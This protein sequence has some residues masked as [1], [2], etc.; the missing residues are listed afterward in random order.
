MCG[1]FTLAVADPE[2][3]AWYRLAGP[4]GLPPRY[5][6]APTQPVVAVCLD[7]AGGRVLRTFRW[8][9]VPS[10]SREGLAGAPLINARAETAP[11]RPA[12]RQAFARG[13]CLVPA[14]GFFEWDRSRRPPRASLFHPAGGG[15][16]SFA[17]LWDRWRAPDGRVVDSLAILTVPANARVAPLHDRMPAI[18][19][20]DVHDAWLDPAA[21]GRAH[22]LLRPFPDDRVAS[23]PVGPA[24]NRVDRDDPECI[25]PVPDQGT[26]L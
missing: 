1:R 15:L 6:I 3:A 10:W 8:G 18:L 16:W 23:F 21:T 24:V 12:F 17:G 19:D 9:L 26:L 5:N 13:R 14:T 4:V 7:P 2:L 25:A 22:A 11:V 20:R